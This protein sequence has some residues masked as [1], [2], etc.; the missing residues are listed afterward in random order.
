MVVILSAVADRVTEG[1]ASLARFPRHCATTLARTILCKASS[2]RGRYPV[3][4][5]LCWLCTHVCG[6]TPIS[7]L[8]VAW[9]PMGLVNMVQ[10]SWLCI[11]VLVV[12]YLGASMWGIR[13]CGARGWGL[14]AGVMVVRSSW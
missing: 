14:S 4:L 11:D 10:R 12:C 3:L 9:Q 13:V 7:G 6:V 2:L 5:D 8:Q 1:G